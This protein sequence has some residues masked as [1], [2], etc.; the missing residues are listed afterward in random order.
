M[1]A[2]HLPTG[3]VRWEVP[4]GT[5]GFPF[6]RK[7]GTP[8][9]GGPLV[10]A[11]GVIFS[12]SAVSGAWACNGKT[13]FVHGG[14]LGV[15]FGCIG[16]YGARTQVADGIWHYVA[17]TYSPD[18]PDLSFYVDGRPDGQVKVRGNPD[19][20]SDVV[21][22]GTAAPGFAAPNAFR[23]DIDEA[24]IH[25]RVLAPDEV[26]ALAGGAEVPGCVAH[27]PLDHDGSD[28][29]GGRT[30][31]LAGTSFVE[32]QIGGALHFEGQGKAE[33]DFVPVPESVQ[34]ARLLDPA[35]MRRAIDDLSAEFGDRYPH[36]EEYL[37]RL[38][39]LEPRLAAARAGAD[40]AAADALVAF[41]REALLSN[42][43]LG[44][45]R[46]L[47][48]RRGVGQL[49]LPQNW[50]SNSS[51]PRT[52]YDNEL[53]VL[54][55]VRPDGGLT[56][57]YK[58]DGGRFVGDAC[59]GFDARTLL[60]SMP[61]GNGRWQVHELGLDGAG[62][63][64]LPLIPDPDVDN[65]DACYLPDG[66]LLFTSTAPF[67]G[68]PCVTGADHVSNLYLFDP[69]A[70]GQ[71]IRRL[72][73]E[74][75]H[76]WCPTV[77]EDGR[78][79]YLRWEYSD[80][81]HYVARILFTM[82][83]DGTDQ[84]ERYGSN[85]YW[86]NAVFYAK[87]IPGEPSRFV[88]VVGGHHDVPRMGELVLFDTARGRREADGVVQ[89]I[90]G[91]GK[92]VEPRTLD[93]LVGASWPKFLHPWPLSAKYF[94]VAAKPTAGSEW[95]LY[96]ADVFDNLV[97]IKH[98]PGSALLEP[99]PLRVRPV[100]PV[101]PSRVQPGRRDGTIAITDIYAGPGLAGVPAGT[102]KRLRL[103]TYQFAYHGMGGQVNRVGLDGPW[104]IKRVLGTVPVEPDGSANFRVP[105]NTPISIQPLDAE[106]KA[107][108]LM[109]SWTTVMPGETQSC[110]G[111][112]E[113]QNSA[114]INR[115]TLA[116][117]RAPD[118][119]TP[120]YGATRGFSFRREVQPVLNAYCTEC[121]AGKQAPDLRDRPDVHPQATSNDYNNGTH[122]P[123]S[124]LALRSFVRG[125]S[126]ESDIH[127]LTPAEYHADTTRLVRMLQKGH[128]GVRLS[129]EAWDRLITWID[130][131]TPAH[132][133]WHEIVGEG[134]VTAQNARRRAMNERYAGVDEDPEAVPSL[135]PPLPA[136]ER[137]GVRSI[138]FAGGS[139]GLDLPLPPPWQGG[140]SIR[141]VAEG[142]GD[143][144][145]AG[146]VDL[147]SDLKLDLVP[148]PAGSFILGDD[149]GC[150]DEQ[151]A[152]R[153]TVPAG[154]RIGRTEVTNAQFAHFD[155]R[156]DSRLESG[157]FLQFSVEERGY[158]TNLPDQPVCRVSWAEATAF[159]AWLSA[160]TGLR[161]RLP[162]EG[163]WEYAC[164]AGTTTPWWYG[165]RGDDFAPNANLADA[166][167]HAV[168]TFGWGLPSGAVPPWRPAVETVNDG[169]RV[170]A[171]VGQFRPNA[172]GVH[173]M[174]G[175]VAEWTAS[176]Y[177]PY[178]YQDD[179]RNASDPQAKKV[180]RGGSWWDRPADARSGYRAAYPA[181]RR[182]YDVGF[183]V[184]C[185]G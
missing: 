27:W 65:Y 164:R 154:L 156:H 5:T 2:I 94:L 151:P 114:G 63:R 18:L 146:A 93:G 141:R 48:V 96:L 25:G 169:Y 42:P 138:L 143:P 170:S 110:V 13:F 19:L 79:M 61:G 69:R 175:N 90:P 126:I 180:V 68:V 81:P 55:P 106:G 168:D 167:L 108:Q 16:V 34:Q 159:C 75:D 166:R 31:G 155:P 56:T 101:I 50:Q 150:V 8:N 121:H 153:V 105:A 147:G 124:Y 172:W 49:G 17:V 88:A 78:V 15:D 100:P 58:P 60:F 103:F 176:P 7:L 47:V 72:T 144:N 45:D 54:S 179:R 111:C 32:G 160:R 142:G 64:Q 84:R 132:G 71:S 53:M 149:H 21:R 145:G 74:Q 161:L 37:A 158:P 26:A 39:A 52:G 66:K 152:T 77:L 115:P 14:R 43:L 136:K 120:W 20:D 11:G 76:D 116:S 4:L 29:V 181:W 127:L 162:T 157:D 178:P 92:P 23:G 10:T 163:E 59:L 140:G 174:C 3:Q 98:A 135:R 122:F 184:V 97:L 148:L 134:A 86:P 35:A 82:N 83:P 91:W 182:V 73:F 139:D 41:Q 36:G 173:D 12:K 131:N 117:R 177:R 80:I 107:L 129:A 185:E 119:I 6:W 46:L 62:P 38:A 24:R 165:D 133:T 125:P 87:P 85:S 137:A 118:A 28:R 89:R 44:F 57:L 95:G 123:P 30:L 104:D 22:L 113:P 1:T 128:H 130:L 9:L 51:L 171:P 67:T 183:R 99:I 70:V 102:V 33:A 109:R 40:V 112:H